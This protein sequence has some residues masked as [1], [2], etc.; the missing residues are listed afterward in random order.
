M[1]Y[2]RIFVEKIIVYKDRIDIIYK[3][4]SEATKKGIKKTTDS[5]KDEKSIVS[6]V[7]V[8]EVPSGFE[9]LWTV[10]QTAV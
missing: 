2:L 5:H 6:A 8:M 4:E 10:L 3:F 1:N 9:P 7:S